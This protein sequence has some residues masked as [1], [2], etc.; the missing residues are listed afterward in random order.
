[1]KVVTPAAGAATCAKLAQA[2]PSQR[3]TSK[4]VSLLLSSVQLTVAVV[5][6]VGDA[7]APDGAS[8][9]DVVACVTFEKSEA[10]APL[11]ART[12]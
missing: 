3:S 2:A 8:G 10:P 11:M 5:V 12:R 7:V 6:D 4:P 1:M 9:A